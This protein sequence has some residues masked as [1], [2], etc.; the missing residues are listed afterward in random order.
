MS[1]MILWTVKCWILCLCN[2]ICYTQRKKRLK[3]FSVNRRETERE[4]EW[5]VVFFIILTHSL[6]FHVKKLDMKC[7]HGIV[8][9]SSPIQM[10]E[11]KTQSNNSYIHYV[12]L[13]YAFVLYCKTLPWKWITH[14]NVSRKY[15]FHWITFTVIHSCKTYIDLP[16]LFRIVHIVNMTLVGLKFNLFS[17][18]FSSKLIE[19]DDTLVKIG[20]QICKENRPNGFLRL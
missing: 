11:K 19:C 5:K 18:K 9:P 2:V 8:D 12:N 1:I 10:N 14:Q 4:R 3:I 13:Y 20:G 15:N 6:M 16:T 7:F 17:I